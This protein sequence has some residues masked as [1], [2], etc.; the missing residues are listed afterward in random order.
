MLIWRERR[1]CFRRWPM[2]SLVSGM[3]KVY[4]NQKPVLWRKRVSA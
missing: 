1:I 3:A 4:H 2:V